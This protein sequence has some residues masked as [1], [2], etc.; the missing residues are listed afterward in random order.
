MD[1]RKF[2]HYIKDKDGNIEME[3]W[4]GNGKW[5][6]HYPRYESQETSLRANTCFAE[7]FTYQVAMLIFTYDKDEFL[8]FEKEFVRFL[9][10]E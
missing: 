1:N 4:Y 5:A 8:K 7:F 9:K 6:V 3:L 2:H 10:N